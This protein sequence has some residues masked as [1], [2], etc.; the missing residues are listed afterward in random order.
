[1][2]EAVGRIVED[3]FDELGDKFAD[4]INAIKSIRIEN[5][6]TVEL[7]KQIRF[8]MRT[9]TGG[10]ESTCA[11]LLAPTRAG[12]TTI[13][14]A[15]QDRFRPD[16]RAES[17]EMPIVYVE[18]P[19]AANTKTLGLEILKSLRDVNPNKGDGDYKRRLAVS[20]L[21]RR[22]TKLLII[23][24]IQR[25]V[26]KDRGK[27]AFRVSDWIQNLINECRGQCGILLVGTTRARR[28]FEKNGHLVGR[29]DHHF[30]IAP[31]RKKT[32]GD[33]DDWVRYR[34]Y[35]KEFDNQLQT[36]GGFQPSYLQK[37][38][39]AARIHAASRGYPGVT[40]RIIRYAATQAMLHGDKPTVDLESFAIA[41]DRIWLHSESKA[42]NPFATKTP[43]HIDL[44]WRKE[45]EEEFD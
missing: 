29:T 19:S 45:W 30:E 16:P 21:K 5:D 7:I 26:Q 41:F 11:S 40:A 34:A 31:Y 44:V 37:Q 32:S 8:Y 9:A 12:K 18:T 2:L 35:L 36:V 25:L 42:L 13:V 27:V 4:R 24:E 23:D 1:M 15:F 28:I 3:D 6:R 39:L 22:D 38:D 10:G 33:E 17:D 14:E 20:A 43:P